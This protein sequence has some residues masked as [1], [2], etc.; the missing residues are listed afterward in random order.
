VTSTTLWSR[1]FPP[2]S[3]VRCTMIPWGMAY[4]SL[5]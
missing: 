4:I 1:T 3:I 2:H 5:V